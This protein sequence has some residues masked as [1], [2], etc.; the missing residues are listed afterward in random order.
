NLERFALYVGLL[1]G[2]GLSVRNGLKGWFNIYLGDEQYWSRV[3]WQYLGPVF[4]VALVA[5]CVAVLARPLSRTFTG[6]TFPYA[7]A[8][9]WLVLAV[10]NVIAQLITGPLSQWNEVSFSIYYVL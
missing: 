10:Q 3:L 8:L 4:L 9:M 7:Y 1:M 6:R 5:I 2:L